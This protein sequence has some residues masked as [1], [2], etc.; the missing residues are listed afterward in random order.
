MMTLRTR[1]NSLVAICGLAW[2]VLALCG[3]AC[4]EET[5][6]P[7]ISPASEEGQRAI[8]A[9]QVP[10]GVAVKLFAAEPM[11]ANPVAFT[12]DPTGKLYCAVDPSAAST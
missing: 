12:I 3:S 1:S 8:T 9:F 6:T 5:Y 4:G 11:L 7:E 2:Q 10:E